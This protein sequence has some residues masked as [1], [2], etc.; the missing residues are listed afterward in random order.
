MSNRIGGNVITITITSSSPSPD[1]NKALFPSKF[2]A[3]RILCAPPATSSANP[4]PSPEDAD[5][6]VVL[7]PSTPPVM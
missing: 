1:T 6:A 5:V 2:E 3:N 4:D 7:F